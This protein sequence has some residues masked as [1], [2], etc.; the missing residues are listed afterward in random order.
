[1][2]CLASRS[3]VLLAFEQKDHWKMV[4]P[5]AEIAAG[6]YVLLNF[7]DIRGRAACVDSEHERAFTHDGLPF[8][9]PAARVVAPATCV[10]VR[11]EFRYPFRDPQ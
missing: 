1:M 11:C 4:P 7:L 3:R 9:R 8:R 2:Q 5:G 6:G 10:Q